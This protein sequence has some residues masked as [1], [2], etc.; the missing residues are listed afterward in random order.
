MKLIRE[1]IQDVRV[2]ITEN[3][4]KGEKSYHIEGPMIVCD[5]VN[6]NGRNYSNDFQRRFFI[7][8]AITKNIN[9]KKIEQQ[10]SSIFFNKT[11]H[12]CI[13]SIWTKLNIN[14]VIT[15]I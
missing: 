3:K 13:V 5:E 11:K 10:S 12:A 2:V 14:D 6:K 15:Y 9:I 4:E 1:E 8:N 7:T